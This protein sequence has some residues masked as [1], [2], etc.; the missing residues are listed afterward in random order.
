MTFH[1]TQFRIPAQQWETRLADLSFGHQMM[2]WAARVWADDKMLPGP[3]DILLRQAFAKL[4]APHAHVPFLV[5]MDQWRH[6][7]PQG[8]TSG[9][10]RP[11]TVGEQELT[12]AETIADA[13]RG[14]VSLAIDRSL[15]RCLQ[16]PALEDLA[17]SLRAAGLRFCTLPQP[18]HRHPNR[19]PAPRPAGATLH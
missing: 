7:N 19:D 14:T 18:S 10:R 17:H 15:S 4:G 2:I 1:H 13:V 8:V 16:G 11:E 6:C 5:V 9:V 3:R 12:V